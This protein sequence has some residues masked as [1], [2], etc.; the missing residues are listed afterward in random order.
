MNNIVRESDKYNK[1]EKEEDVTGVSLLRGFDL[2]I[3]DSLSFWLS[4]FELFICKLLFYSLIS[5]ITS[6]N[7]K[8]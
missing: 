3:N 5:K 8:Y 4:S 6:I 1:S 2:T 7:S